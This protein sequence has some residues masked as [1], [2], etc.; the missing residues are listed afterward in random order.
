M[1]AVRPPLI[2]R[3]FDKK[4]ISCSIPTAE[5]IIYLTFD[6]GPIPEI[7]PL[8]LNILKER[9]IKATFFCVGDNVRKHPDVFASIKE[10][11]HAVGNHT[12]H[13]LN[14]WKTPP[15]QYVED[16]NHC[17]E[18]VA[19]GLFRP[20]YGRITPTQYYLLHNKFKIILWS[21]LSG[22]YHQG[23]SK[24]QCL[25]NVLGYTEQGSIVVFHDS[26]TANENLMYALP[27]FIDHFRQEG[28]RFEKL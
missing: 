21:V 7:T 11:G 9:N 22:D 23:I 14:G 17:S 16:V 19:S 1:F 13:H 3:I 25:K 18:F 2:L 24:E 8:V 27:R 26:L 20:P 6:D 28:Y 12:F 15:A 10:A 4:F 5:K